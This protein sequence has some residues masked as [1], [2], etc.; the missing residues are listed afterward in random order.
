MPVA[1]ILGGSSFAML[2]L[3]IDS[4]QTEVPAVIIRFAASIF[5]IWSFGFLWFAAN[6]PGR[7]ADR[8]T[9][10]VVVVTGEAGRIQR[11]IEVLNLRMAGELFVSGVNEDVTLEEFSS[12]FGVSPEFMDCCV[13]LGFMAANTRGNALEISE[14]LNTKGYK[15]IRFIT[16]DWHMLRA[17]LEL[18]RLIPADILV[19]RDAMPT[20]A[21]IFVLFLEYNKFIASMLATVTGLEF[22]V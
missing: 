20:N 12:E 16:S 3:V 7:S 9:D 6:I 5:L 21:R 1:V 18:Q 17:S 19:V 11:G 2:F 10:A 14:W 15:S 22:K 4:H 8:Q 13:E